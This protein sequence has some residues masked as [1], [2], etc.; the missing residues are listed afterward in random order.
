MMSGDRPEIADSD[1][2][3]AETVTEAAGALDRAEGGLMPVELDGGVYVTLEVEPTEETLMT[4]FL[5]KR[6]RCAAVAFD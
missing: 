5:Q 6:P 3:S 1:L 2:A 4:T